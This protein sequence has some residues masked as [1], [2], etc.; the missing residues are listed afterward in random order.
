M[1]QRKNLYLIF[2]EAVNNA[3]K[4]SGCRNLIVR[5]AQVGRDVVLRV[6]DD[7]RGWGPGLWQR[8]QCGRWREWHPQHACPGP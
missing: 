5:V 3:A 8:G 7:G 2:K 1:V 4:Y 6:A